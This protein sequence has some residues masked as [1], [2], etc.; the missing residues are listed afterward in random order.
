VEPFWCPGVTPDPNHVCVPD[1]SIVCC[2]GHSYFV[3]TIDPT[4]YVCCGR[5][6]TASGTSIQLASI[7]CGPQ[8]EEYPP[9]ATH[10]YG[11][12]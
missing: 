12:G 9:L 2:D 8:V 5:G 11:Q 7:G 3:G 1:G 4:I 10:T 6:S